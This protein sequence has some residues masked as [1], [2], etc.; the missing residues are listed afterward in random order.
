MRRALAVGDGNKVT[1]VPV[2]P[3]RT[4]DRT[5]T[6]EQIDMTKNL[7]SAAKVA[8]RRRFDQAS[9]ALHWLTVVLIVAQF[10]SA[11]LHDALDH[12]TA[13]AVTVQATHQTM[14][15]LTWIVGL[16]R[17]FWRRNFAYLPPFPASMPKL[18]QS[19]AKANEYGLYALLFVQP[20]TG[21]GNL[22]FHGR[23][24]TLGIWEVPALLT[25]NT[26]IRSLLVETHEIGAKALLVLIGLH[27]GAALFHRLVL[28][29]RV[30]QR[31]LPWTPR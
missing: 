3:A 22:L 20:I 30:L 13:F 23:P 31:M 12:E 9:I 2:F 8:E 15:V 27:A 1:L 26:A 7:E 28:R 29:D 18:Q 14:G 4:R 21:L 24:F 16:A 19:I 17:L 10:I 11:W 6:R 5:K 25:P